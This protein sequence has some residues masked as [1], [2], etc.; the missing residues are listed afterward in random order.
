MRALTAV[1]LLAI[2][3]GCIAPAAPPG[4]G[5]TPAP[6]TLDASRAAGLEDPEGDAVEA[7]PPGE[8]APYFDL[9]AARYE[10]ETPD[11]LVF[12]LQLASIEEGFADVVAGHPMHRK[13]TYEVCWRPSEDA[14]RRCVTLEAAAN[15]GRVEAA[16]ALTLHSKD[17]N[18]WAVCAWPVLVNIEFGA[19]ATITWTVPKSY[20]TWDGA[21]PEIGTLAAQA[22]WWSFNPANPSWHTAYSLESGAGPQ[23]QHYTGGEMIATA[24]EAPQA[25]VAA[26]FAPAAMATATTP[27]IPTVPLMTLPEGNLHGGGSLYDRPEL[28][29]LQV[30]VAEDAGELVTRFTVASLPALPEFDLLFILELG[31]AGKE[32]WEIG[33]ITEKE[34]GAYGYAGHCIS[35]DCAGD[36][37]DEAGDHDMHSH[38]AEVV[39]HSIETGTP[40]VV[41][42]RTPLA[43]FP[44]IEAGDVTNFALAVSMYDDASVW[45]NQYGDDPR[46]DWHKMSFVDYRWGGA[47]HVFTEGNAPGA[48]GHAH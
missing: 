1:L 11:A 15:G 26:E 3:T 9:L 14:T 10:G 36:F 27:A 4:P 31:V 46:F 40:G 6:G 42:V 7:L 13:A 24:D 21:P 12:S 41:E 8:A 44:T 2:A 37:G 35:Y 18:E 39:A 32:V 34:N 25:P 29:L 43:L 20:A 38:F 45:V 48:E 16:G 23:H 19:P 22:W 5:P 47:P 17:C 33:F 28:D 30:D